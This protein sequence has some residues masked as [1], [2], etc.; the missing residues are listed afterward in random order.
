MSKSTMSR[1]RSI[2]NAFILPPTAPHRNPPPLA[3]G[4]RNGAA[5]VGGSPGASPLL[6]RLDTLGASA[7]PAGG[8][9]ARA[10]HHRLAHDGD[11]VGTANHSAS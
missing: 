2:G 5:A 9:R 6:N 11:G 3:G 8:A 10:D 1:R 7:A 4:S